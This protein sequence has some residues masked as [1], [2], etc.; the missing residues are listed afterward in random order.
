MSHTAAAQYERLRQMS[1]VGRV[2]TQMMGYLAYEAAQARN[3][4]LRRQAEVQRHAVALRKT[5]ED[6]AHERERPRRRAF[7]LRVLFGPS[8]AA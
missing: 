6:P 2:E 8:R 5:R 4:E 3:R 7:S 1:M